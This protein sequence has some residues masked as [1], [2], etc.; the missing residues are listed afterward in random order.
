MGKSSTPSHMS[1]SDLTI[2]D[3]LSFPASKRAVTL[4]I[5]CGMSFRLSVIDVFCDRPGT[6]N[7][8][9]AGSDKGTPGSSHDD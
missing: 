1:E 7:N 6:T 5:A 9:T 3:I 2:D 4:F 8:G